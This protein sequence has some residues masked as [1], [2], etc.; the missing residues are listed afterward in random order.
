[1]CRRFDSGSTQFNDPA[2]M[3]GFLLAIGTLDDQTS[4]YHGSVDE[5]AWYGT[6]LT[7]AQ[8]AAHFTTASSA[9]PGAYFSLV[10]SDG[11]L[12]QL[13]NNAVPEPASLGLLL[14]GAPLLMLRRRAAR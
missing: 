1:M 10:Q 11:A 12:L 13:S 4:A 2:A 5:V 8:L 3:R 6:A 9:T 14:L 7:A